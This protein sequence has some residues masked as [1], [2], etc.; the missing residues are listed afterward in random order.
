MSRGRDVQLLASLLA[1]DVSDSL[2]LYSLQQDHLNEMTNSVLVHQAY[3][4]VKKLAKT[5]LQSAKSTQSSQAELIQSVIETVELGSFNFYLDHA[6][7]MFSSAYSKAV[8]NFNFKKNRFLNLWSELPP[9]DYLNEIYFI[10]PM[11]RGSS[12]KIPLGGQ[13]GWQHLVAPWLNELAKSSPQ[14]G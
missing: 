14:K 9:A 2:N 5:A 6:D 10:G 7:E 11:R 4:H 13:E 3:L 12:Q 1:K 8:A